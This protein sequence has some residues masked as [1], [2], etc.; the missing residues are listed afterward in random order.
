MA[1]ASRFLSDTEKK[2]AN[3]ELQLPAVPWGL[4]RFRLFIYGKPMKLLTHHQA[5]EPLT[6]GNRTLKTYSARLT[7]WLIRIGYFR[8][9]VN[10]IA[11]KHIAL[12][13][14]LS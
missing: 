10:H 7:R 9:N 12:T 4:E 13:D 11:G 1:F 3:N 2:Y 6:T 5:L 14:C 8:R